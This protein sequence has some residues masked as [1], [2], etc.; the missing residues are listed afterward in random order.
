M[1]RLVADSTCDLS[2]ELINQAQVSTIPLCIVM[3]DVSFYDGVDM[4]P[5]R[6][7]KWADANKTTPKTAAASFDYAQQVLKPFMDAG[8]DI[9]FFGISEK[10]STTCNV[11]RMI[12][13]DEDYDKLHVVDS[14]NLSTGIGL[15]VLYAA[16]LVKEGLTAQEIVDMVSSRRDQ[17]RASFVV[18]TLTYL[19]RGGRCSSVT[20]LLGNALS[21]KPEIVVEDG[22]MKVAKKYRGKQASVILKYAK[23][24]ESDLKSADPTCV[25]ITHSGCDQEVIDSVKT[26]LSE[27]NY[28]ENISVTSAGGVISSHCGPGTLGVLFY[29]S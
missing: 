6:I 29:A 24:L 7:Y 17:V 11:I 14:M 2:P 9:I 23:D 5:D 13:S 3:D 26:Y 12:G 20:A 18:E 22:A 1:I 15:Q 16:H 8:D 27:H 19:A 28:F 21:L 10:M 4:T 25:F